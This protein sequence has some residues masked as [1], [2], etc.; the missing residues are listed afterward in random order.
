MQELKSSEQKMLIKNKIAANRKAKKEDRKFAQQWLKIEDSPLPLLFL[1]SFLLHF[2]SFILHLNF[3]ITHFL[4]INIPDSR[5]D[6]RIHTLL[7]NL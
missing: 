5:I 6:M 1:V 4:R 3:H 7:F 2:N